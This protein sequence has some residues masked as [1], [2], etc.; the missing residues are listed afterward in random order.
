MAYLIIIKDTVPVA[1]GWSDEPGEGDFWE[2]EMVMLVT[3]LIVIVPLSIQRDMANLSFTSFSSVVADVILVILVAWFA[4]MPS[5]VGSILKAIFTNAVNS[6]LFIGLG[7]LSTAMACQHSAFIVSGSLENKTPERWG[8]VT[9]RS[10]SI[11]WLCCTVMGVTGYLGFEEDTKGDILNNFDDDSKAANG[12]RV[13]LAV[14]DEP[15]L[16]F[17]IVFFKTT[18][19]SLILISVIDYHAFYLSNGNVRGTTRR[20]TTV[21]GR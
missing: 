16:S 14:S 11:A 19:D 18:K 5:S 13:L 9:F 4:P 21:F 10:L 6:R 20:C 12:G 15:D 2:T 8:R 17:V 3:S 7:V 1:M